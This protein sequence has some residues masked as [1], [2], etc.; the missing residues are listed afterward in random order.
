MFESDG[1]R[2]FVS[3]G[4][5]DQYTIRELREY[6]DGILVP[7]TVAAYQSEG[8]AGFVLTLSAGRESTPYV[9]DPRFPL[10]QQALPNPKESHKTLARVLGDEQLVTSVSPHPDQFTP[11]RIAAI[12]ESWVRFNLTYQQEQSGKFRKYADRLGEQLRVA[13]ASGPQRILAPY[14]AVAGTG[15]P[16]YEKS[17]ALYEATHQAAGEQIEVTRVLAA[18]SVD[19]L[20]ELIADGNCD[21][22]CIWVSRLDELKVSPGELVDYGS[23]IALLHGS[24]RRS[25]A[26]YGGFFAVL[27]SAIGLGGHS[28]GIGYGE[29]RHWEELPK[30]GPPPARYYLPTVHRY[31]RQEDAE[32]L[33]R[34]DRALVA[35]HSDASPA[36]L[37]YH[38]LMVHSVKSR[39]EELNAFCKLRLDD[40]IRYL[41]DQARDFRERVTLSGD[42]LLIR[43]L[44]QMT[45]HLP[46]WLRALRQLAKG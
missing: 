10:F 40:S 15:D 12:A 27:L 7:G 42:P 26:L 30:S 35:G 32:R 18:Q 23:A 9:I 46:R 39:V 44:G 43:K 41:D 14:F 2:H 16:W 24:E 8:T 1:P 5:S 31:V 21:D 13:D 36:S 17:L 34:T 19:G 37:T 45:E 33:W 20:A 25:F 3:Y 11:G 6:Y 38:E 4:A 29:N 28:H 22:V